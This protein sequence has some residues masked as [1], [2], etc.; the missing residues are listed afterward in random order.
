MDT[1]TQPTPNLPTARRTPLRCRLGWHD[2][3]LDS[4]RF[5]C[6][7]YCTRCRTYPD[8]QWG[9]TTEAALLQLE[10][11]TWNRL[12]AAGDTRPMADKLA[13]IARIVAD[14]RGETGYR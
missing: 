9:N 3:F 13:Y 10:R 4:A 14:A 11:D 5:S 12:A 6:A 1:D 7:R 8:D 2:T